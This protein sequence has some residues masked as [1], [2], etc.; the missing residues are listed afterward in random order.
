MFVKC[1]DQ[2]YNIKEG[3]RTNDGRVFCGGNDFVTPY[4]FSNEILK[5]SHP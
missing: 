5:Q 4:N 2:S 3:I 1:L